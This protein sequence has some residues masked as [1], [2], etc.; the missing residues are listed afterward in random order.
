M[1]V[2][3][4]Y[5][6]YNTRAYKIGVVAIGYSFGDLAGTLYAPFAGFL[7]TVF[8]GCFP[9]RCGS[10]AGTLTRPIL[11]SAFFLVIS[12]IL[13]VYTE[14]VSLASRAAFIGFVLFAPEGIWGFLTA[15]LVCP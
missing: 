4:Y 10:S 8:S 1:I 12:Q 2:A 15:R 9:V 3:N 14:I 7:N 11:G 13:S 5:P 6:R